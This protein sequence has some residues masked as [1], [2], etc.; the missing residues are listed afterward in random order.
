MSQAHAQQHHHRHH[1][2]RRRV[3]PWVVGIL[4]LVVLIVAAVGV[5]GFQ[6]YKQAKQVQ[7]HENN[8]IGMLS[9]LSSGDA[10]TLAHA[11]DTLPQIAHET[12]QAV[13][14][15]HGGLWNTATKMPFVGSDISTVQGM[16]TAINGIVQDSIPQFVNVLKTLSDAQISNGDDGVN[17]QPIIDAVEPLKKAN[18]S[19]RQQ[20]RDYDALPTPEIGMIHSAYSKG[21]TQLN[22]LASRVNALSN[23]FQIL[24]TLLGD[25]QQRTY[26]VMAMTP[27]EMRSSGGLIGSVGELVTS[28]GTVH[29]GD[30]RS[31]GEYLPYG[32]GDHSADMKR[33][34]TDEGPLHMSFDIRDLAVF[35]NTADSAVAMQSVWNRTPWG[36]N[37]PLDGVIMVD[38]VF[39]QQ[40]IAVNGNVTL[41]DGTVLTGENTAEFLMNTVYQ[42]YPENETDALFGVVAS[43]AMKSMFSHMDMGKLYKTGEMLGT[44]AKGRHFTMYAFDEH[45]EQGIQSAGFTGQTPN[46]ETDPSVGI[47]LTEQNPSKMGWYIKRK[48]KIQRVNCDDGD[49]YHVEFMVHN[50]MTEEE[51]K[52]L[53][54]YITGNNSNNTGKAMEKILFYA[55]Q[56]GSISNLMQLGGKV[57]AAK[58]TTI[59]G[60]KAYETYVQVNPGQIA[61]FTFDVR[62]SPKAT[63]PLTIDQTPMGWVDDGI[64]YLDP[65]CD[66]K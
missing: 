51:A 20:V 46:S 48:A 9:K 8:A 53:P 61:T 62:V 42:K 27:S 38:P 3:W 54:W 6:L 4:T 52:S 32:T 43:Q 22:E 10:E 37:T 58:E 14:I 36:Q 49:L 19:F 1:H 11:G 59:D 56:G 47:Y 17:L 45:I 2:K 13:D 12:Q 33:V 24:P 57:D 16:T 28:N 23:T 65:K 30:F 29:I 63:A 21:E 18:A 26:A 50:T 44:M 40:L 15:A 35:P 39:L 31:N 66:T 7:A 5:M 60:V 25:G 41:P 64:T 55:P 34:F